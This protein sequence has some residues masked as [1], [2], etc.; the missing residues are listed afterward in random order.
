MRRL[1]FFT[2]TVLMVTVAACGPIAGPTPVAELPTL[3]VL[4]TL[5]NTPIP[6]DTM[7][8]SETPIPSETPT[9][10]VA[11]SVTP[12]ITETVSVTPSATITDTIT[13]TPSDT[14]T[15]TPSP[16]PI[17]GLGGLAALAA[18][19]TVQPDFVVPGT[20]PVRFREEPAQRVTSSPFG[21]GVV[22]GPPAQGSGS[23]GT[24]T[25]LG[26]SGGSFT[27]DNCPYAPPGGFGT[28]AAANPSVGTT[29][30]C[31][32][33][34]P[35]VVGSVGSA[36]QPYENGFMLW[37]DSPGA[38]GNIYAFSNS[39]NYLVYPDTWQAGVDP[40]TGGESPPA[41]LIEPIRGFGKVWRSNPIVR[42]TLGWAMTG[43]NG[44]QASVLQFEGG[45]MLYIPQMG[46]I[47]V[48]GSNG[49]WQGYTGSF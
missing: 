39:G 8:P 24:P 12:T 6:S 41:G 30:G 10:T 16:E 36:Y 14:P 49:S 20:P 42:N 47:L 22:G 44:G 40:E 13:P 33:G 21:N 4:P 37:V 25:P 32:L 35:P 17:V 18:Q 11:P 43:E 29:V 1:A 28:I 15:L 7:T 3:A 26:G 9:G 31:P 27:T 23:G 19:T 2:L 34:A 45:Q 38:V 5:T 48:L 46:Q